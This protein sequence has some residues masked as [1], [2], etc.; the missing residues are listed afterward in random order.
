MAIVLPGTDIEARQILVGAAKVYAAPQTTNGAD[1]GS[2]IFL[3]STSGGTEL[4]FNKQSHH[5]MS[6]Q[7]LNEV[8][9]IPIKEEFT[10]KTILQQL[11]LANIYQVLQSGEAAMSLTGGTLSDTASTLTIGEQ[12]AVK[13]WQLILRLVAPPAA[14]NSTRLFQAWKCVVHQVGAM[15]FEKPKEATLAITWKALTDTGA[16]SAGKAAVG[17]FLD[18]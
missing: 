7:Y 12:K 18:S 17:Q 3:G 9:S 4:H 15:K 13:Y 16:I 5:I 2:P 6:D 1:A 14:T 11:N 8:G 10:L